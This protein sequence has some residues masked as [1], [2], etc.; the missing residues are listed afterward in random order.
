MSEQATVEPE[1]DSPTSEPAPEEVK[2]EPEK[3]EIKVPEKI[4]LNDFQQLLLNDLHAAAQEADLRVAGVRSKHQIVFELLK[5]YGARGTEIEG[6]GFLDYSGDNFGFLK[7]P[8]FSFA[9]NADD[10]YVPAGLIKKHQLAVGQKLRCKVRAPRDREKYLSVESILSVEGKDLDSWEKPVNFD[11]LT[12]LFPK[13]RLILEMPEHPSASP[14]VIDLVAPLG[15]GQRGLIVAPPRG[16]KT[17]LLKNIAVSIHKNNPEAELIVLLLDERPEE[18]TDFKETVEASV[19]SSTFDESSRRHVEVADMVLNRAKRIVEN[20]KDVVILL[21]SLTR[22]ARAHNSAN[23]SGGGGGGGG[24]R[25][26]KGRRGGGGPIG[27]GGISPKAL[28][29]SRRFFGAARN[30]EEGGSLTILATCLIETDSRMDDVI[31]EEFKG[32]GNM[33]ITLDREMAES[34]V[35][36]AIHLLK[37]GTR[38]D[39]LLYNEEEFQRISSLRRQLAQRPAPE[40]MEVLLREI[41]AT[42]SNVELLLRGIQ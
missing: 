17:I 4:D 7:W 9:S 13:E 8:D 1:N 38:K 30:V 32:T 29:R 33:E 26:N 19:Y 20:G 3:P 21:D 34:R 41:R 35:F 25:G 39:D 42:N 31:F 11:N 5:F 27:S 6:E 22:L 10:V 37:S 36:P 15:K 16:G 12:A 23:Q 28:E 18:V 14:R 24:G 2:A 40:A